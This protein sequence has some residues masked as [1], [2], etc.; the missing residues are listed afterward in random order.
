MRPLK[1]LVDTKEP[2]TQCDGGIEARSRKDVP[3]EELWG[4]HAIDLPRQL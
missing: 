4:L 1:Q 2:V 3:I